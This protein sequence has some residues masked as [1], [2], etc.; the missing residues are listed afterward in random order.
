MEMAQ[1]SLQRKPCTAEILPAIFQHVLCTPGKKVSAVP[2]E[3]LM[4]RLAYVSWKSAGTSQKVG[5][6]VLHAG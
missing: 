5:D 2:S 6:L 1:Y 4:P 3:D